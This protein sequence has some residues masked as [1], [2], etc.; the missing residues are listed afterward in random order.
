[1]ARL[2]MWNL[3]SL[4]GFFEGTTPWSIDWFQ[5]IWNDEQQR[6]ALEQLRT[7]SM[8][9]FGRAT[10]EG[11]AAYWQGESGEI[12]GLMN[13]LPKAVV[14]RSLDRADWASTRLIKDDAVAEVANLK[15]SVDGNIFVFGSANLSATLTEAGLFDEYRLGLVPIVL[16]NGTPL[17]KH[18]S[19]RVQ[20]ELLEA[21]PLSS[22][23]V[24]LR[25]ACHP[26]TPLR[27]TRTGSG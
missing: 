5:T 25:Y 4:D 2:I 6:H 14:S 16:G 8:L 7:A 3:I 12:A 20:L 23:C 15:R 24:I 19:K 10:Y 1:M 22:G 26:S 18:S 27:V 9:L 11:M 13:S 21:R 17:F